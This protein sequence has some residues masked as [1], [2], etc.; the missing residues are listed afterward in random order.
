MAL[1]TRDKTRNAACSKGAGDSV[2]MFNRLL[3]FLLTGD[4]LCVITHGKIIITKTS[5]NHFTRSGIL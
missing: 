4:G 2:P 1:D 5:F 3:F